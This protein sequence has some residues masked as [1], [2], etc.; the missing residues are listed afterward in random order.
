MNKLNPSFQTIFTL[1]NQMIGGAMLTLPVMFRDSGII[2]GTLIMLAS[3]LISYQ[4]CKIYVIHLSD[5]DNDIEDAISRIL[6]RK[7]ENVFKLITG[8]YLV[9][10]NVIYVELIV[11]QLYD[12]IYFVVYHTGHE[13]WIAEK[14]IKHLVFDRFSIQ[15]LSLVCFFLLLMLT[16]IKRLDLLIKLSSYG[17]I[18]VFAYITFI[19]F[20]FISK[21]NNID[22]DKI[23]YLDKDFGNL[24]GTSAIAF[25]IHTVVAS[26]MKVNRNQSKNIRDLKIAYVLGFLLYIGIGIIGSLTVLGI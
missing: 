20:E 26:V 2:T 11:D 24:A 23:K 15:Y 16:F 4:T 25:T 22:Y 12:V 18:S 3:G 21:A 13:N 17:I 10:L 5:G 14:G 9:L 7:W 6:N 1:I 19:G 8:I